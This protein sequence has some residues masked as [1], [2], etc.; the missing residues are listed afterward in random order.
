MALEETQCGMPGRAGSRLRAWLVCAPFGPMPMGEAQLLQ[1]EW[2]AGRLQSVLRELSTPELRVFLR[3]F[4]CALGMPLLALDHWNEV[5]RVRR[6]DRITQVRLVHLQA[7]ASPDPN[8][9]VMRDL[10]AMAHAFLDVQR[11]F[12]AAAILNI[13]AARQPDSTNVKLELGTLMLSANLGLEAGP[14]IIEAATTLLEEKNAEKALPALRDYVAI[15]PAN[16][17]A[18]RLLARARTHAVQHTLVKRNSLIVVAV[19]LAL[20]VGAVVQFRSQRKFDEKLESVNAHLDDPHEA[21]RLLDTLF[22]P[23]DGRVAELRRTLVEKRK[24]L[25]QAGRTAWMDRYREAQIECTL[26]DPVLGLRRTFEMPPPPTFGEG[27]EP[28]PLLNDLFNSLAARIEA[29]FGELGDKVDEAPAQ[30]KGEARL[31]MLMEELQDVLT[32][33]SARPEAGEF[34]KRIDAFVTRLKER[35]EVRRTERAARAKKDNLAQQDM[36]IGAA[37]A[38][39]NAGDYERSLQLFK[40]LLTKDDTGKLA[41]LLTGEMNLV[42]EKGQAV[43]RALELARAGRQEE[44]YNLLKRVLGEEDANTRE[45]PWKVESCPTGARVK[46][47]DGT[48]RVTPFTVQSTWFERLEFVIEHPGFEPA[49]AVVE[50]PADQMLLLSRVPERSWRPGGRIEALPVK[51][52][53]DHVVCDRNGHVARLSKNSAAVWDHDLRS[54]GG[55]AHSPVFLSQAPGRLLVVTEDGDAWIIDANTGTLEGP[56]SYGKPLASGPEIVGDTARARFRDGAVFEWTNRL[57]PEAVSSPT[58]TN[59]NE[60]LEDDS[61]SST[62][63][64]LSV[65]RRRSSSNTKLQSPWTDLEVEVGAVM[66]TVRSTS[67]DKTVLMAA[68]DGDWTYVAWEAPHARAP[69][70]RLWVSDGRGLRSFLP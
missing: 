24:I 56:W 42:R 14:W 18:R 59:T 48:E 51:V 6:D 39:A 1:K 17:E 12:A 31:A 66:I 68:R 35:V 32:D 15:D 22:Q 28:L 58:P 7:I 20:A 36:L 52:G 63:A 9:P 37:R 60:S 3:R 25:D 70:G 61:D 45:L 53:E 43:T 13:A 40:E 57:K 49:K 8:V 38:H 16:R 23:D 41:G 50:H 2:A 54:L 34:K 47:A 5:A 67:D 55:V 10:L 19:L 69:R 62:T 33:S 11:K 21:L 44:A 4:D 64:G 30:L 27:E 46:F 26:G 29:Q 65:L